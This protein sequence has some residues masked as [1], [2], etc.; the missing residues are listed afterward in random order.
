MLGGQKREV[1]ERVDTRGRLGLKSGDAVWGER[2]AEVSGEDWDGSGCAEEEGG[3]EEVECLDRKDWRFSS[4][5]SFFATV[6]W[7]K[8]SLVE[9]IVLSQWFI[10]KSLSSGVMREEVLKEGIVISK[11]SSPALLKMETDWRKEGD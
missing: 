10:R 6:A 9:E 4:R 5:A 8:V 1:P 3:G 2:F 7:V 11:S